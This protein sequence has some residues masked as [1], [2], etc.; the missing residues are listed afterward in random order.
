MSKARGVRY[1]DQLKAEVVETLRKLRKDGVP[2]AVSKVA[3][4]Y[5]VSYPS[6]TAWDRAARVGKRATKPVAA[7]KTGDPTTEAVKEARQLSEVVAEETVSDHTRGRVHDVLTAFEEAAEAH[8]HQ[9]RVV[10]MLHEEIAA[11]TAKL[12]ELERERDG[13]KADLQS[14]VNSL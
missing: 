14:L 9:Q 8:D 11:H 1:S 6:V 5:G 2:G 7:E 12:A 10:D 3:K 4:E 13:R